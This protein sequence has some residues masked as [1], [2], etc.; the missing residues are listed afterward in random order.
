MP[1]KTSSRP[2]AKTF[3]TAAALGETAAA[4]PAR[5]SG[6]VSVRAPAGQTAAPAV[7]SFPPK[8]EAYPRASPVWR[9]ARLYGKNSRP[10][11]LPSPRRGGLF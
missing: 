10:D 2:A 8:L 4:V 5:V 11:G 6:R 3:E 9:L 1:K 7:T